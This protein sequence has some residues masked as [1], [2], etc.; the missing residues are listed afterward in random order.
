[1]SDNKDILLINRDR[2][3]LRH[4]A[5]LL[6]KAGSTVHTAMEMRGALSA[7]SAHSVGLI[8][9]DKDLQDING[10]DRYQDYQGI[11]NAFKSL[12]FRAFSRIRNHP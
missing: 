6:G 2:D 1:M 8:I 5:G 10:K 4:T 9:C 12:R 3:F 7:L 11:I